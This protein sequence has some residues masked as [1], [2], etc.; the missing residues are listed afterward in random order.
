MH[1]DELRPDQKFSLSH[2][3]L[4]AEDLAAFE[5]SGC[6]I[7]PFADPEIDVRAEDLFRHPDLPLHGEADHDGKG[8]RLSQRQADALRTLFYPSDVP[9]KTDSDPGF[10]LEL[11]QTVLRLTPA[12]LG[13]LASTQEAVTP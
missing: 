7:P 8:T 11:A 10:G 1:F 2:R 4:H 9:L 5:A 12:H 13:A 3:G 6:S